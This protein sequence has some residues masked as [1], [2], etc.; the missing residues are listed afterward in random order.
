TRP[1][2]LSVPSAG[3]PLETLLVQLRDALRAQL[4]IDLPDLPTDRNPAAAIGR[5]LEPNPVTIV[6]DAYDLALQDEV[7]PFV[8]ALADALPA[9]SR[10]ILGGRVLPTQLMEQD[11]LQG[12]TAVI[13]VNPDKM[14]L[15]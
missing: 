5:A 1:L 3:Y 6:L 4:N 8:V 11:G 15:D 2:F 10:L 7:V 12:K 9:G 14:M 13:P